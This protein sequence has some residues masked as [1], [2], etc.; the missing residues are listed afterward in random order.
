MFNLQTKLK[1]FVYI[2]R[3]LFCFCFIAVHL[4]VSIF[5]VCYMSRS[6]SLFLY[7]RLFSR[8]P[9]VC[10]YF[11]FS[12]FH[13]IFSPLCFSFCL[14]RPAAHHGSRARGHT[15]SFLLTCRYHACTASSG[16]DEAG[17]PSAT[18]LS[19]KVF[20]SENT[21]PAYDRCLEDLLAFDQGFLRNSVVVV[22]VSACILSLAFERGMERGT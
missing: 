4:S 3:N 5:R 10:R 1:V 18:F 15:R 16:Q 6:L 20:L 14:T 13:F 17:A 8:S 2:Y 21:P 11:Y 22:C 12:R 19:E 7:V 9:F